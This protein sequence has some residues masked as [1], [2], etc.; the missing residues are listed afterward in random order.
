MELKP[1]NKRDHYNRKSVAEQLSEAYINV[2]YKLSAGAYGE[3]LPSHQTD[4]VYQPAHAVAVLQAL[5]WVA[6]DGY[7][8]RSYKRLKMIDLGCGMGNNLFLANEI[9][10]DGE[11]AIEPSGIELELRF[12][13]MAQIL[14]FPINYGDM[15]S[16]PLN[17]YDII[18]FFNSLG[19]G[20]KMRKQYENFS[21]QIRR[22]RYLVLASSDS[23]DKRYFDKVYEIDK[24]LTIR[25]YK[26][27]NRPYKPLTKGK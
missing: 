22:G 23:P 3:E 10:V 8:H 15:L 19:H 12:V 20:D 27:N 14:G 18:Y 7:Q 25:I 11:S 1:F 16:V 6:E 13:R 4:C 5:Q 24:Y 2:F 21:S 17:K 9:R 26:R